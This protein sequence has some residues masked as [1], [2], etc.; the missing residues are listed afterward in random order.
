[1]YLAF[2]VLLA[3]AR[4]D[5]PEFSSQN[6]HSSSTSINLTATV[7]HRTRESECSFR[8]RLVRCIAVACRCVNCV[9][10][11]SRVNRANRVDLTN[12]VGRANRAAPL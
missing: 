2:N 1:M 5:C 4:R 6:A 9:N 11:V 10:R 7:I 3:V 8:L 12:R